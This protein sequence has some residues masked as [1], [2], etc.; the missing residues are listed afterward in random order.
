MS[1]TTLADGSFAFKDVQP[2]TYSVS[3]E[4]PWVKGDGIVPKLLFSLQPVVVGKENVEDLGDRA[5]ARC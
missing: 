3:T 5:S 2:G 4:T 1:A